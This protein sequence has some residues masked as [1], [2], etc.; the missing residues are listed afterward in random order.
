MPRR[1]QAAEMIQ[2]N[3]IDVGQQRAQTANPPAIAGPA[4]GIPVVNRIA[5]KLSRRA[6]IIGRH[7]GNEARMVM[8]VDEKQLRIGPHIARIGRH[9]EGK[10]ANQLYASIMSDRFRSC[11]FPEVHGVREAPQ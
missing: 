10:I 3:Y 9:E 6:E 2:A 8:L 7:T 5:P 4:M 11:T 1:D